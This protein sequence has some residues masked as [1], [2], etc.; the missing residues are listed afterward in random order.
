MADR[1][2]TPNSRLPPARAR[3]KMEDQA[4]IRER[5]FYLYYSQRPKPDLSLSRH[6]TQSPVHEVPPTLPASPA[7]PEERPPRAPEDKALTAFA[8]LGALRLNARRCLISFFDR[9]NCYLLAEAT[10]TLCLYTGAAEKSEDKLCWGS[11]IFPKEQSLC[12]YTVNLRWENSCVPIEAFGNH[13]SLV[14]NDLTKDTRFKNYPFVVGP[15][16]SRFYAGVPIRSPSGHSIGTYCVLDDT[17]RD[18]LQPG[19]LDFLK[20]MA[21]TV[22]RHLEMSRATE[23]QRRGK[24]MV[25]SLGS[26]AEGKSGLEN[27]WSDPWESNDQPTPLGVP[28]VNAAQQQQQQ[29]QHRPH[30]TINNPVDHSISSGVNSAQSSVLSVT[31][32]NVTSPSSVHP[33]SNVVTPATE[34]MPEIRPDV[35]TKT[36]TSTINDQ[37]DRIAPEIMAA[38]GRAANMI[39]DA[40]EAEGAVFFDAKISTFGGLVDDDFS[41]S[42]PEPDKP[43]S[44]LGAALCKSSREPHSLSTTEASMSESVLRHL[45]RLYPHGQIFNLDDDAGSPPVNSPS[46]GG[47]GD[48]EMC[49]GFP[50]TISKKTESTRSLDD[51]N[52][53]RTVFPSAR[54]L[55]LYP[56]WDSH[57]DR[58]FA[59]AFIWTSDP[60]RVFTNEQDLSYL[61]AFSNSAMAEVAR[62]DM[63]LAD[64]AKADFIS[65]ISHELRS[66]LHGIL[67][68]TDLL[69]DSDIDTQQVSHVATIETCGKT[70]LE[71]INHVLDFAK[72][73]NL[74]RGASKRQKKRTQSTKHMITPGHAHTNDI[75]TLINDVDMSVLT[76]DVVESVF[77]G[78][79][80]QR[81]SAQSYEISSNKSEKLAISVILD[82]NPCDNYVFRTQP[83]AW[84]RVIMNLFGNSLKYTPAGYIK[85]KLEVKPMRSKTEECCEFRFTVTDS[86]IGMSEDYVNNRLFHSFAQENPLSQGTGLGLSIV[87]QI[88]ESLGGEVEVRSERGRGTKF[89]VTCP[90]KNSSMSPTFCATGSEQ[91][92]E[93]QLREVT[94]RTKGMKVRFVGFDEEEEYFVKN[95]KN[96]TATKMS[97][98]ALDGLCTDWFGME[99]SDNNEYPDLVVATETCAKWLRA[100]HS[101]DPATASTAPVIVICEGAAS[102]QSTTAITVPGITFECIGQPVGPHKFAKALS[103]CLDRN[104]NRT[105]TK[106]TETDNALLKVTQLSLKEEANENM[107][108]QSS[109]VHT[110]DIGPPRPP[111]SSVSSAPEVRSVAPVC[112][113]K[114][115]YAKPTRALN[116]LAVDDN[117]INLRLLRTF[118]D[119]LGHRHVLAVNGLEA[120]EAY[121]AAQT[122]E[123]SGTGHPHAADDF[124]RIDVVLMDINMPVMDGLE[125][126]RAIR[127]HEIRNN[128]PKVTIIALTGVAD[129]E[130]QQEA[131]LSG[132]NLFLIKPVRLADLEV[133]LKGVITGQ[134][135]ANAELKLEEEQSIADAQDA[136]LD[137]AKCVAT[138]AEI[139]ATAGA[140][141][142]ARLHPSI[143]TR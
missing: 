37:K 71:T 85:V 109:R 82:I 29:Q 70:L 105:L 16:Y 88:V 58:W 69:K 45:L 93:K 51:E 117:P 56:L 42:L 135:N 119:K 21:G 19:E 35:V 103:S 36:S 134:D 1:L 61:A 139:E 18:G 140:E 57:R 142:V 80:Y 26:F 114:S 95:L 55:V 10:K 50:F 129:S 76:E 99:R 47:T 78:Y 110:D 63:K 52:Y 54:S 23:D 59:T 6:P 87:K 17:P 33:A 48:I 143:T 67:G 107:Q 49:D 101:K 74:T 100:Q 79:T 130:I 53:L 124:S 60:M 89:A 39:V 111:L 108:P 91:E 131:N 15:P 8:Q 92:K 141:Q 120:L 73:N 137:S 46:D 112:L 9:R 11:T 75:M 62:L 4:V 66:P 118:V 32:P 43:C 40:T 86:G 65:S 38:F 98:K 5:D 2:E 125:A 20:D 24:I 121:K 94:K 83:G 136:K 7:P 34:A 25:K 30:V 113:K 96:K 81:T 132:I 13:P 72:I 106:A 116:C 3:K 22:M 122:P 90:L 77:A 84:R 64:S 97:L 31:S 127:A 12:N 138:V 68:M 115:I 102:A 123:L 27:W 126:T 128:L 41:E 133:I 28:D 44:I 104:A 14:V